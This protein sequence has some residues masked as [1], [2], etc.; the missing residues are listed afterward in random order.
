MA[1]QNLVC[2]D[3]RKTLVKLGLSDAF[4]EPGLE[5]GYREHEKFKKVTLE[6]LTPEDEQIYN[7]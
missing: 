1:S 5:N 4:S 6:N 7:L 3:N 2:V